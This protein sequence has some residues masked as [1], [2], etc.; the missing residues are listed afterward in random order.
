[1][2]GQTVI[3]EPVFA[4]SLDGLWDEVGQPLLHQQCWCWGWDIRRPAGNLLLQRGF[5]RRRPVDPNQGS[6]DYRLR[7]HGYTMGLWGFGVYQERPGTGGVF[8]GRYADGPRF[9]DAALPRDGIF[10]PGDMPSMTGPEPLA[11]SAQACHRFA[12]LLDWIA[13]Y[14]CWVQAIEGPAHRAAAVTAW[15]DKAV[16]PADRMADSWRGL[17]SAIRASAKTMRQAEI[18][19]T[20]SQHRHGD[21]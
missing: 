5:R 20:V 19:D 12:L 6:S 4:G 8:I 13:R 14:E 9:S 1:V 2:S 15:G 21:R 18:T 3:V 11:D 10:L 16:V 17:A 7:G